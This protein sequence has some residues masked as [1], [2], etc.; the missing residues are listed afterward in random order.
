MAASRETINIKVDITDKTI[1]QVVDLLSNTTWGVK[2]SDI[3]RL[4]ITKDKYALVRICAHKFAKILELDIPDKIFK[5]TPPGIDSKC[6]DQIVADQNE[7]ALIKLWQDQ[8]QS[9][10]SSMKL[11]YETSLCTVI[12]NMKIASSFATE[13][14]IQLLQVDPVI[15]DILIAR[16]GDIYAGIVCIYYNEPKMSKKPDMSNMSIVVP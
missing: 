16:F 14:A 5:C 15:F 9:C 7:Q 8:F 6:I 1:E 2:L 13:A 11:N 4:I 3:Q 12:D 10:I